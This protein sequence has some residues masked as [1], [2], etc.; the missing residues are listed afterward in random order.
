LENKDAR[1]RYAILKGLRRPRSKA[2]TLTG[3]SGRS[4]GDIAVAAHK[5]GKSRSN[6][7]RKRNR[8]PGPTR[9]AQQEDKSYDC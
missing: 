4:N 7:P 5:N 3:A 2:R 1:A 8:G 6:A 9:P